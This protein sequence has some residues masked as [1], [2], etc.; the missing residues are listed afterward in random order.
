M[1]H[2]ILGELFREFH[3]VPPPV[4]RVRLGSLS[5]L[6]GSKRARISGVQLSRRSMCVKSERDPFV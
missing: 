1:S 4:S 6:E 5:C 3:V 2:V